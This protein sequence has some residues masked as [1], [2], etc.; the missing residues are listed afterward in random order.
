M[1]QALEDPTRLLFGAEV[2]EPGFYRAIA[3][4]K[5]DPELHLVYLVHHEA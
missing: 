2:N 1:G 5:T 3:V 4:D